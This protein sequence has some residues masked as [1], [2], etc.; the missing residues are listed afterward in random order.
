MAV[1]LEDDKMLPDDS[2]EEVDYGELPDED[3]LQE[4]VAKQRLGR[5][6]EAADNSR[7]GTGRAFGWQ[8]GVLSMPGC[9]HSK[10]AGTLT[11]I[12]SSPARSGCARAWPVQ[13]APSARRLAVPAVD[14]GFARSAVW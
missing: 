4:K 2:E 13:L 8:P 9:A 12:V 3:E 14:M 7:W 11:G 1:E 6:A 5:T 10:A